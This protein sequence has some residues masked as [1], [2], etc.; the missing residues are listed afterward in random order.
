[1]T[2]EFPFNTFGRVIAFYR[3]RNPARQKFTAIYEPDRGGY[4]EFFS[5]NAGQL[6][7]SSVANAIARVL[8]RK[9]KLVADCFIYWHIELRDTDRGIEFISEILRIPVKQV[10]RNIHICEEEIAK[11]LID[12]KILDP[13]Y[14]DNAR[15]AQELKKQEENPN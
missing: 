7:F 8:R 1:M 5:G 4:D 15:T 12:K 3:F 2:A 6:L 9:T 13:Y 14:E 10:W 11:I